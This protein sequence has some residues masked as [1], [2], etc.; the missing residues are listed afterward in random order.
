MRP[1]LDT[2]TRDL[3]DPPR[4]DR[5]F[6]IVSEL[7]PVSNPG[8][9]RND[10]L[11]VIYDSFITK[12]D[13]SGSLEFSTYLG[14]IGYEH[15]QDVCVDKSGHIIVVGDTSSDD[16]PTTQ[17]A[18]DTVFDGG[19]DGFVSKLNANGSALIYSTFLGGAGDDYSLKIAI[20]T[21]GN[22]YI[23]GFTNST[24]YPTTPQAFDTIF[25][26][27]RKKILS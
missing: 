19:Y 8:S 1:H 25:H 6:R 3:V 23:T 24:E 10:V 12:F 27:F 22:S 5:G 18:V 14:G 4:H 2:Q 20:D 26:F 13:T 11:N 17:D 16:F 15:I 9:N 7:G 21:S